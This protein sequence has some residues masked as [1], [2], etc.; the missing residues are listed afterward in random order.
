MNDESQLSLQETRDKAIEQGLQL[1]ILVR[2]DACPV[3]AMSRDKVYWADEAPELPVGGCLKH[4][5]HCEYRVIDPQAPSLEEMLANGIAAVKAGKMEEAQEWLVA[6]LQID[7]YHEQ[8]WL[9]LSGAA[10]NDQDR[11]DCILEVLKINPDNAHAKR[12][13]ANLQAKGIGLP[14]DSPAADGAE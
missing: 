11:L 1:F 12:G 6:L 9:W 5:C 8:A 13:L 4:D 14:P 10:D 3:C 7:R 2:P